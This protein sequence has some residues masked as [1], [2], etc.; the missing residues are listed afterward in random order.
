MIYPEGTIIKEN[1][2]NNKS[3]RGKSFYYNNDN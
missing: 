2:Y 1:K 3:F